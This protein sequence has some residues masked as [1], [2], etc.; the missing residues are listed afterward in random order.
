M[1]DI[2]AELARRQHLLATHPFFRWLEKTDDRE[3]VA[4]AFSQLAFWVASAQDVLAI[5]ETRIEEARLRDIAWHHRKDSL[6]HDKWF[7]ED[8]RR[9]GVT[10][11]RASST[12]RSASPSTP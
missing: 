11:L 4:R 3:Q 8:L 5:N 12:H 9:L 1:R 7:Y 2:K 10:A 6:G